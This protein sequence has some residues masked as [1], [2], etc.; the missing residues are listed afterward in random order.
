MNQ[1]APLFPNPPSI[2]VTRRLAAIGECMIEIGGNGKGGLQQGMAGDTYNTIVYLARLLGSSRWRVH[3]VTA[4]GEDPFSERMLHQWQLEGIRCELVA[5][6]PDK[7]PGLYYIHLNESGERSFTYWRNDSAARQCFEHPGADATLKELESFDLIYISGISLAILPETSRIKLLA[8]LDK[9]RA[10]GGKV[11]FDNNYRPN[12]WSSV[13]EAKRVYNQF[14]AKCDI[15]LLTLEDEQLLFNSPSAE[16]VLVR[17]ASLG[18]DEIVIKRGAEPCL[19][20]FDHGVLSI[21]AEPVT[22]V[23]DTTAA[24]DSFSGAYLA[25]RLHGK[26]PR[27]AAKWGHKLASTVI[28]HRGGILAR[29]YMPDMLTL[30]EATN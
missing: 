13:D 14:L 27:L 15:A 26:S 17:C 28:Q 10:K 20:R 25:A 6:I 19:V 23:V 5:R 1:N 21:P 2:G 11:V 12:L 7:N 22:K 4:M 9:M 3:Y 29:K 8:T 18:I 30:G 16:H 24:G